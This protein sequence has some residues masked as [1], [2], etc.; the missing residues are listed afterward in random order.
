MKFRHTTLAVVTVA[1]MMCSASAWAGNGQNLLQNTPASSNIIIS[2]DLDQLRAN[3]LYQMIWG[4]L[5]ADA[6]AQDVLGQ[7]EAQAGFDP[8]RDLS[9]VLI[10]L[11][12]D[13][14]KFSLIIEGNFNAEQIAAFL[15]TL[16]ATEMATIQYGAYTV[17]HDPSEV[18]TDKA[19]FSFVNNNLMA[20]G[21]QDELGAILDV[22]AGTGANV[23]TN[24]AVNTLCGQADAS[25]VFWFC[26]IIT[27]TMQAE[28][29]GTPMAGMTNMYGSG[30]LTGGLNVQYV[31]GTATEAEATTMSQFLQTSL[32]EART[33]PEIAQMG[34]AGI[35]DAV[36]VSS[37]AA[38]VT[39]DVAVP[40]QTLNQIIGMLTAIMAAQ[41]MSQQP[42]QPVTPPPAQ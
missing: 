38:N 31:L 13:N 4:M 1:L 16:D 32:A 11:T 10:S 42:P 24:V 8:N 6:E 27:P 9:T 36:T 30:N 15:G 19:Y 17:F 41:G 34:L 25:G 2:L 33:Q 37:A 22:M 35:L 29:V 28:M 23:T 39:I 26:G 5:S 20:V 3:P 12:G 40:E 7:M 21:T 14:D 18:G